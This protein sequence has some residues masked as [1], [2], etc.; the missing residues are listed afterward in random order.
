M[1]TAFMTLEE[2]LHWMIQDV[3][4]DNF[5]KQRL[6][7]ILQECAHF[8]QKS[9]ATYH[10]IEQTAAQ[11]IGGYPWYKDDQKNFP[12]ATSLDGVCVGAHVPETIVGEL[13]NNYVYLA[14]QLRLALADQVEEKL[15]L[16]TPLERLLHYAQTL[17]GN[18]A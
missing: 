15:E 17:P 3:Q 11:A 6:V 5:N 4:S 16:K 12:G 8:M 7:T 13:A 2:D 14:A 9:A 18:H 1:K 10:C